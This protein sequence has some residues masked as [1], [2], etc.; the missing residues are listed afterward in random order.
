MLGEYLVPPIIDF[1]VYSRGSDDD[2][3]LPE[4]VEDYSAVEARRLR[5]KSSRLCGGSNE[6]NG[7]TSIEYKAFRTCEAA[8]EGKT[9]IKDE[10]FRTCEASDDKA[11]RTREASDEDNGSTSAEY[12]RKTT[13]DH[14]SDD[15][16]VEIWPS[17][18]IGIIDRITRLSIDKMEDH[19][20]TFELSMK[21]ANKNASILIDK[22]AGNLSDAIDANSRS[23]LGYGSEF[24][25]IEVIADIYKNHPAWDRM[26]NIL[27][28][29]SDWPLET[30][31]EEQRVADVDEALS[32]GNHKG[33]QARSNEL[34]ELVEKDVHFGYALPL[35]LRIAK[36][37][38]GALFAPMNIMDQNSIDD[39]GR[40]IEKMRLT[41]DQSYVFDGSKTSVNSR[42]RKD[43]L[44]PCM[45]GA[46]LRRLI[47][48]VIAARRRFPGVPIYASKIDFKSAYRRC[49]LSA[50]TAIQCCT[51]LPLSDGEDVMLV[52]LRET[53]GGSPSPHEWGALA[54][55]VCDLANVVT[56]DDDWNPR[57]LHSPIQHLVPAPITLDDDI[58][59]GE[60][61]ELIVNIPINPRGINDIYVDDIIP[62]TVGLPNTD[63][64]L[65]CE[66]AALLAIHATVRESHPDDPSPREFMESRAKLT[67]EAG[68]TELKTILGWVF[69]FRR[70]IISLPY[71]KYQAWSNNIREILSRDKST[72][73]ELETLVGRLGH[74]GTI[75]PMVHH[76]LSRLRELQ[77]KA[78][79]NKRW[80]TKLNA[81]CRHDLRLMLGIL[82]K[83]SRGIDMNI[84]AY[85]RPTHVYRADS[86]PHGLGGYSSDGYAWRF[87]LP[88]D[89]LFRA[90][91]NLL[92]F[93]ASIVTPWV[94]LIAGRLRAGDCALSMTDSTTSAGWLKKTNFKEENDDE[95]NG[96]E[97]TVRN[98]AARK[99]ASLFI[100]AGVMEYTQWFEG[101][102]NNVS[103]SLSRDFHI[104]D[105]E[106]TLLLRSLYPD[107]LPP[108]FEI[109]QLPKEI[110]SWMT[111]LLSKLPVKEQLREVHMKAKHDL[112]RDG[113]STSDRSDSE[114]ILSSTNSTKANAITSCAALPWL[115]AKD[116]FQSHLMNDWLAAQSAVPFRMFARPSGR[117]VDPTLQKTK[118]YSLAS[119]Y[120]DYTE[121]S[122]TKILKKN[123]KR[124][125]LRA[126]SP[127]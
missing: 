52:Y 96:I 32:F 123:N 6:D 111:S 34:A 126:S 39:C 94:D 90:S 106:L 60:G 37:L 124:Q 104:N 71:N 105:N 87:K 55:P 88:E 40:I 89:L 63:N 41:H 113:S 81:E 102:S 21:A 20:F 30:I 24:R 23:I 18:L 76:F 66:S 17:D 77:R 43:E 59:F 86:C 35:P 54:E 31:D 56:H 14:K 10:P 58:P 65:R 12:D 117:I 25:P 109:V 47:N 44:Q 112:G 70:L 57:D 48:W 99:H 75:I 16:N 8:D 80:P 110:G 49:H 82:L 114:T 5:G 19:E 73:K 108:H 4:H 119:F 9:S 67:A 122:K 101:K 116:D 28:R 15:P 51:Q 69:D 33:A 29:G 50:K 1:S 27:L 26:K 92:E 64:M 79:R 120:N 83:A 36:E 103:D 118:I 46:C 84:V 22:Y 93:I 42:V 61:R 100:D 97:G 11:F 13:D 2:A 68:L 53:F 107:Q 7:V 45:Y 125:S 127:N 95:S 121:H 72:S 3:V 91:N 98:E 85:R 38:P 74:V 78:S 62:L 115:C